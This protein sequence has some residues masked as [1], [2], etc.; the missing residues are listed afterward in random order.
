[1]TDVE[2]EGFFFDS[3]LPPAG[4]LLLWSHVQPE[5]RAAPQHPRVLWLRD[6]S[7]EIT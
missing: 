6:L 5:S 7:S 1:M 2:N 4:L 3:Q